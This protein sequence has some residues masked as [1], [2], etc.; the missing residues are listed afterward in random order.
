MRRGVLA[1]GA[2]G[3]LAIVAAGT[4]GGARAQE[5]LV[6]PVLTP[7]PPALDPEPAP[8]P[9][10][11]AYTGDVG[12]RIAERT[13]LR[14]SPGGRVVARIGTRTRFGSP[15]ILPV[16]RQRGGWLGVIAAQQPN[17][18]LGWI[19]S[20]KVRLLREPVRLRVDLS[21][22]RLSVIRDGRPVWGMTVGIGS[23]STPT[24][25]GTFAVTDGLLWKGSPVYGCC[26]LALSGHQP[27]V[28]QGWTGGDRI[29]VHG[30][31]APGTIGAAA[32]LGCLHAADRDLRRLMRYATLGARVQITA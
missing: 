14:D 28:A 29:A 32:S 11:A 23:A 5:G 3:A 17:G 4:I 7:L 18:R 31:D 10:P 24:P 30:T 15:Q 13:A 8:V 21:A 19:P 9:P 25:I 16:M 27:H 26:V 20:T 2:A 12:A 6:P 22:R 1:A